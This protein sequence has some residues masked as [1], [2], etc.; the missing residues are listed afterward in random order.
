MYLKPELDTSFEI[1]MDGSTQGFLKFDI[2]ESM[3]SKTEEIMLKGKL[4]KREIE[5]ESCL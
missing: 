4:F 2:Y 5:K 3:S 1:V